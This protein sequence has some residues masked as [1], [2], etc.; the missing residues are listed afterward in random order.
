MAEDYQEQHR[1][2]LARVRSITDFVMG[3]IL[4]LVG[5]YFLTYEQLDM[6]IFNREHSSIDYLIGG[7]FVLY[8]AWRIYRG[9][10]KDYFS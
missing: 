1:K 5:L 10:K 3:T 2:K 9:Y 6:N 8:G 7:M 4:F